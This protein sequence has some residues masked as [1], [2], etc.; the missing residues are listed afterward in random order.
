M[1]LSLAEENG[2][3]VEAEA[4]GADASVSGFRQSWQRVDEGSHLDRSIDVAF[5]E[6]E[7]RSEDQSAYT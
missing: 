5:R 6:D 3:L 2:L 4:S 1:S 7:I